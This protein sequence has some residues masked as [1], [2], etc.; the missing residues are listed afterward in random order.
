[1]RTQYH[2]SIHQLGG[3]T[4]ARVETPIN[5][6]EAKL[7][8]TDVE[9]QR[10]AAIVFGPQQFAAGGFVHPSLARG[11]PPGFSGMPFASGGAV[12]AILHVGEFVLQPSAVNLTGVPNLQRMNAGGGAGMEVHL[13]FPSVYDADGFEAALN[14]NAQGFVRFVK[15]LQ[16]EGAR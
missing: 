12:P 5:Q 6:A 14:K 10:R 13:H 16:I 15:R 3:D 4:N 1:L 2:A 9:R 8:N 11:V 7:Q